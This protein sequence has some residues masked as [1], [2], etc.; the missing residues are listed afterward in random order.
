MIFEKTLMT[1]AV[2]AAI[3][4]AAGVAVIA[5]AFAVFAVLAP[6]LGQAGAAAVVAATAALVVIVAVL[7][8]ASRAKRLRLRHEQYMAE[9]ADPGL[10]FRL[11]ELA[12]QRPFLAAGAA[13][14]AGLLALKNPILV[15]T[16]VKA[17]FDV[18]PG[19]PTSPPR[20]R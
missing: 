13:A 11:L 17:L 16:V 18:A 6:S 15:A 2:A 7:I 1:L 8:A 3:A 9:D 12:K 14:A 10:M 4:A 19:G 20:S 5:A